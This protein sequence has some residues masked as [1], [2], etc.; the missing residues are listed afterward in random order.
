LWQHKDLGKQSGKF[1]AAVPPHGVVMLTV[2][3]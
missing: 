2:Q 1:G 3:P